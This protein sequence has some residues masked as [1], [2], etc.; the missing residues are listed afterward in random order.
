MSL[1]PTLL[2]LWRAPILPAFLINNSDLMLPG[3]LGYENWRDGLNA[4]DVACIAVHGNPAPLALGRLLVSG[5]AVTASLSN[6]TPTPNPTPTLKPKPNPTPNQVTA[7][8][9]AAE[10]VQGR[11]LEVLHVFWRRLT[12][13]LPLPLPLPLTLPLTRHA[14]A[15]V[16]LA[17]ADKVIANPNPTP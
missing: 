15:N 7:S 4:G 1:L 6:P 8:L 16:K 10:A 9:S 2:A 12:L 17:A 11:C 13:P 14:A 5:A 3:M